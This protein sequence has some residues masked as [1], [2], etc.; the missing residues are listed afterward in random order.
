MDIDTE[1]TLELLADDNISSL[2]SL[3]ENTLRDEVHSVNDWKDLVNI[4]RNA[5]TRTYQ[6]HWLKTNKILLSLFKIP[7]LVGVDCNIF[8]ELRAIEQ[9]FNLG[10]ASNRLFEI[11]IEILL[12]Q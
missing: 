7:E 2:S 3:L 6:K 10:Q 11:L 4:L 1:L 12:S 8:D 5:F 9:P